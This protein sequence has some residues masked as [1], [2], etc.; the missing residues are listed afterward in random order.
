MFRSTQDKDAD[1]ID[2]SVV[3]RMSKNE[4]ATVEGCL[5]EMEILKQKMEHLYERLDKLI[6]LYG[7]LQNQFIVFQQQRVA[8]LN[9]KVNGG[10]TAHG[11]DDRP[12]TEAGDYPA[13]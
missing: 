12:S 7:T 1:L 2:L 11:T 3:E 4:K 5:Q 10:P 8:E 13:G 6:G 9:V